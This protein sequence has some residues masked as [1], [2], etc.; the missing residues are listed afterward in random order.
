MDPTRPAPRPQL[1]VST[2]DY[3]LDGAEDGVADP[4]AGAV[5]RLEE[6][7]RDL[8]VNIIALPPGGAIERHAGPALDVLIH[9]LSG[10]GE[11][12]HEDDVIALVPGALLWLPR[13]TE[14]GFRAGGHGLRYL[15]VHRRRHDALSI[16]TRG[17]EQTGVEATVSG[18]EP[19]RSSG[20]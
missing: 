15:T 3:T 9:V 17:G 5:W 7:E 12:L 13:G 19:P 11:L 16:T 1:L 18:S 6:S 8:D 2:R 20:R 4:A 10:S 14:R